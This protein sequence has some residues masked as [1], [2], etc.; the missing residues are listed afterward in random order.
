[1]D[2]CRS[3]VEEVIPKQL[4]Y[5]DESAEQIPPCQSRAGSPEKG[6][7]LLIFH[8]P[9]PSFRFFLISGLSVKAWMR[10]ESRPE[11][12]F[13]VLPEEKHMT[14]TDSGF[15]FSRKRLTERAKSCIT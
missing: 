7:R 11:R 1:M 6:F 9:L 10:M 15:H 13:P 14:A 2:S 12:G 3:C 4:I 8:L 5:A